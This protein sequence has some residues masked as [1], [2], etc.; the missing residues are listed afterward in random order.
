[1]LPDLIKIEV[2][3]QNPL[4][5]NDVFTIIEDIHSY[6]YLNEVGFEERPPQKASHLEALMENLIETL[7][8]KEKTHTK[9]QVEFCKTIYCH[10]CDQDEHFTQEC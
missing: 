8:L 7:T 1:M 2:R 3:A 9:P 10:H 6:I 4:M 5:P